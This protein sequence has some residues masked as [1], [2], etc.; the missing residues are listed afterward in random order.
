MDHKLMRNKITAN[1]Q[2]NIDRNKLREKCQ[3]YQT[4]VYLLI[5]D[6]NETLQNR[7]QSNEILTTNIITA[8]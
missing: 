5:K 4:R 7:N 1:Y 2:K 3:E 6:M 8:P